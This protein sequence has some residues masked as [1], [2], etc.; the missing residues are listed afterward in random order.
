M[1]KRDKWLC[2]KENCHIST[3]LRRI[4]ILCSLNMNIFILNESYV[5]QVLINIENAVKICPYA[6]ILIF[7][8]FGLTLLVLL[9]WNTP[10]ISVVWIIH[11]VFINIRLFVSRSIIRRKK[12]FIDWLEKWNYSIL[13]EPFSGVLLNWGENS[14]IRLVMIAKYALRE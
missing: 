4:L 12:M 5:L 7:I 2:G 14:I 10:I 3:Y 6:I 13:P 1:D 9:L 8:H 11:Y